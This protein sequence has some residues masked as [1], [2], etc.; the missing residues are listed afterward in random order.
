MGKQWNILFVLYRPTCLT[1]YLSYVSF[2][3]Q[4]RKPTYTSPRAVT[5]ELVT[6]P[7][8]VTHERIEYE[9][10]AIS[11][12]SGSDVGSRAWAEGGRSEFYCLCNH[13]ETIPQLID[14][15]GGK[16]GWQAGRLH[17]R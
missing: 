1:N 14:M 6:L 5:Y 8:V 13:Q 15:W 2:D 3:P 9:R 10:P 17:R 12:G 4:A 7:G 16:A 11:L